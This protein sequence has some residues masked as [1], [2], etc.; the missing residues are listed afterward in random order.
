MRKRSTFNEEGL[1]Q[2]MRRVSCQVRVWRVEGRD[3]VI[4]EE[5]F[6]IQRLVCPAFKT[7]NPDSKSLRAQRGKP[8]AIAPND[9]PFNPGSLTNYV[10][11][12]STHSFGWYW[13]KR[14]EWHRRGA[15]HVRV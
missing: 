12:N 1:L 2:G 3:S 8:Q 14:D 6:G 5:N 4:K 10:S 15:P 9:P 11:K 13:G 7:I